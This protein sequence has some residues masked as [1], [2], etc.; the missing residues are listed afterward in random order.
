[1]E[2]EPELCLSYPELAVQTLSLRSL[3]FGSQCKNQLGQT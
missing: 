1:M 2:L 3:Q